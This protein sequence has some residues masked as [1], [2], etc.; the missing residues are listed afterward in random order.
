VRY[1]T[2]TPST[3]VQLVGGQPIERRR[4]LP[5]QTRSE[6][7]LLLAPSSGDGYWATRRRIE[8]RHYR[9]THPDLA[10]FGTAVPY[11]VRLPDHNGDR[12]M[13]D[14]DTDWL[15]DTPYVPLHL[16]HGALIGQATIIEERTGLVID[17]TIHH[18][19]SNRVGDRHQLSVKVD[20]LDLAPRPDG[21]LHVH[22]ARLVEVSLVRS[23]AW[24]PHTDAVIFQRPAA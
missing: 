17:G 21:T 20:Q 10:L 13:F 14:T 19:A 15:L 23:A 18:A 12:L 5:P 7:D 8:T 22:Q 3:R 1:T 16:E 4:S 6:G 2:P 9:A 24:S 11:E